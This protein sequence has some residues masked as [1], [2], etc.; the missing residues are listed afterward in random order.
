MCPW[1]KSWQ[2]KAKQWSWKSWIEVENTDRAVSGPLRPL[3][4][5]VNETSFIY[6]TLTCEGN[7]AQKE[8][9]C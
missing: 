9:I 1:V 2:Y 7:M 8:D 5:S 6:G 4:A 3:N